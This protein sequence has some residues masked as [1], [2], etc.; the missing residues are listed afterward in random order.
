M[1]DISCIYD[2]TRYT[3][4]WICLKLQGE[5]G[6]EESPRFMTSPDEY[7]TNKQC[8]MFIHAPYF[9]IN[10]RPRCVLFAESPRPY[11]LY[12][13]ILVVAPNC[14]LKCAR[15]F[16]VA[17]RSC[18]AIDFSF[19]GASIFCKFYTFSFAFSK[20]SP[21]FLENRRSRGEFLTSWTSDFH[22][23]EDIFIFNK[24]M[25]WENKINIVAEIHRSFPTY[26]K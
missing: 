3:A 24:I 6:M 8:I 7:F 11:A 2:T 14:T 4:V 10:A 25:R 12:E 26:H 20:V 16:F 13:Q 18:I 9:Y 5:G 1:G 21:L 19:S 15:F 17:R 22:S 23:S